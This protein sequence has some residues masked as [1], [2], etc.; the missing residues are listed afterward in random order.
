MAQTHFTCPHCG[1]RTTTDR[2]DI[3]YVDFDNGTSDAVFPMLPPGEERHLDQRLCCKACYDRAGAGAKAFGTTHPY[4]PAHHAERLA[5][6]D[7][8][9][10][11][12][13]NLPS[14]GR[15][16]PEE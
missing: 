10:A 8:G 2:E 12:T 6:V 14:W 3:E 4:D 5:A 9:E 11:L 13:R 15:F 16:R 1:Q 7:R